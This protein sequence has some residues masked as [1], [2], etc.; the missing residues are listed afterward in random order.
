VRTTNVVKGIGLDGLNVPVRRDFF[1]T[2]WLGFSMMLI[3]LIGKLVACVR[4]AKI[5]FGCIHLNPL[6]VGP[7]AL[8]IA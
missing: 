1:L 3:C 8:R 5:L 4:T 7:L 6:F 2:A